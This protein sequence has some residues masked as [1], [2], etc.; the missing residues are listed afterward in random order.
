[1]KNDPKTIQGTVEKLVFQAKG[2]VRANGFVI[3]IPDVLPGEEILFHLTEQKKSYGIGS[4]DQILT[5]HPLRRKPLCPYFGVCGGCSLQHVAY[6]QQLSFKTEWV[7]EA[8]S[9]CLKITPEI[10]ASGADK[11]WGYRQRI[12]LHFDNSEELKIGYFARDNTTLIDIEQCPIFSEQPIELFQELKDFLSQCDGKA[13]GTIVVVKAKDKYLL[14]ITFEIGKAP[15]LKLY[16]SWAGLTIEEKGK[17]RQAGEPFYVT[18]YM[19]LKTKISPFVFLQ[20]Y[21]EMGAKL[22]RDVV[23]SLDDVGA[24]DLYCGTGVLSLLAAKKALQVVGI[25]VNEDSIA[26]AEDNKRL[27]GVENCN[28]FAGFVEEL[29]PKI[30]KKT[31]ARNWIINPPRQ[32]LSQK[33]VEEILSFLPDKLIYISCM[34]QTLG[35]DLIHLQEKYKVVRSNIYDMFPQTTHVET[36]ITLHRR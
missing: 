13:A 20:N 8:L 17:R 34:P 26:L 25:E 16:R 9:H 10:D 30:A 3:F 29:L 36:M 1:M 12:L 5:S 7:S 33:V 21:P 4:L 11:E 22:Y 24:L 23:A 18:D 15:F 14:K 31:R 19:G 28:F 2:L 32:G 35:R 27:N 6:S